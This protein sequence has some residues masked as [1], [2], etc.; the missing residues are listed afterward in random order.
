MRARLTTCRLLL[1][2]ALLACQAPAHKEEHKPQPLP[3]AIDQEQAK[4]LALTRYRELFRDKYFLNRVDKGYHLMPEIALDAFNRVSRMEDSWFVAVDHPAGIAL[5]ARVGL[6][7]RWVELIR[8]RWA[9][10]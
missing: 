2:L 10:E 1:V 3:E 5:E 8:V 9:A 6:N 4:R 7:G